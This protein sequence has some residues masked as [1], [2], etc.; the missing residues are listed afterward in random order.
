MYL[1]NS[2]LFLSAA[3]SVAAHLGY[4]H[5]AEQAIRREALR[6]NE[7]KSLSHCSEKMHAQGLSQRQET[8]R[9]ELVRML[10]LAHGLEARDLSDLNKNH[11]SSENY[12]VETNPS[13]L[14]VS[15]N[16]CVL[17]PEVMEGP[18]CEFLYMDQFSNLIENGI[19]ERVN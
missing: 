1:L 13:M 4:N 8:R 3:L 7:V 2:L 6:N 11:H 9:M 18:Y 12:T 14:F 19:N 15:N 5:E 17:S 10:K 16:S